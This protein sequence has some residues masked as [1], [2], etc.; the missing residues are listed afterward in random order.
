MKDLKNILILDVKTTCWETKNPTNQINEVIKVTVMNFNLIEEKRTDIETFFINPIQSEISEYCK[1][2]HKLKAEDFDNAITFEELCTILEKRFLSRDKALFTYG[3][4]PRTIFQKNCKINGMNY[5][6][7]A[8]YVNLKNMLPLFF[9]LNTE[10]KLEKAIENFN[11]KKTNEEDIWQ[12]LE[13]FKLLFI[14][15]EK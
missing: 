15:K 5:P 9:K 4:F 1:K 7:S 3:S 6:F 10:L 13:I 2:L 12:I 8:N 11:I 14:R